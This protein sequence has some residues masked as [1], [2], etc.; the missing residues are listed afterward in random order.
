MVCTRELVLHLGTGKLRIK[1]PKLGE[2]IGPELET[3]YQVVLDAPPNRNDEKQQQAIAE[4]FGGNGQFWP[5]FFPQLWRLL[6]STP[7]L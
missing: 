3:P 7:N 5:E 2:Y 6:V 1:Q 4:F